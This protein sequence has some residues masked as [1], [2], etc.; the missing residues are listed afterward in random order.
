MKK[1]TMILVGTLLMFWPLAADAQQF[2]GGED[3]RYLP[4]QFE[5]TLAGSGSNDENFDGTTLSLEAG[6]GYFLTEHWQAF[7]RQ[8]FA[9]SDVTNGSDWNASTRIGANYNFDWD[10]W[11]PFIGANIGWVYGDS[12][13]D[14]FI[15]G[16]EIG[17]KYFANESTF[18]YG[19]M[20]YGFLFRSGKDAEDNWDDGR[21]IYTVGIGYKF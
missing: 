12:I 11:K 20:E 9:Y 5:L 2:L 16:P 15:A 17:L 21:F 6:L 3:F 10:R 8:G 19:M 4:G 18:L 13:R 7:L 1:L 14:Q